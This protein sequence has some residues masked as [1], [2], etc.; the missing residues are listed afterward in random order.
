MRNSIFPKREPGSNS[1]LLSFSWEQREF[2]NSFSLLQN[3][4][5]SR[6]E[7]SESPG[8][9]ANIHYGDVL[10]KFGE[11]LDIEEET[12]PW[13]KKQTDADK[14]KMSFLQDGDIV[15]ADTAEDETAG[16]CCEIRNCGSTVIISG[17]HTIPCRP[18]S[19]FAPGYLGYYLNSTAF[20]EQLIP[21]MQGTK[22]VSISKTALKSTNIQYPSDDKEQQKIGQFFKS[23]DSL[24]TLHQCN[25]FFNATEM[26]SRNIGITFSWEQR[27]VG[28]LLIER[29][30]QAPAND[31]FPLMA[32]IANIG[33][34]PKGDRYD[35]S[36][37]V[38]DVENKLY[39]RTRLGDFIYSSNNL[40]TG[41]IGLNKYGNASISPVYSIFYATELAD[42]EFLGRR[43]VRK[44]FI[45]AMIKWRQGVIYGQWRIHES[46]FIKIKIAVPSVK[47]QRKIGKLL[48]E[49][50]RLITLHQ[51][52]CFFSR[53]RKKLKITSQK[54]NA[55]EQRKL[56]MLASFSKGA[57]YSKNDLL[58]SGTPIILYG[59]L[60]TKYE[61]NITIVNTFVAAKSGSIYSRGGE[62]IVPASG[63]T[64]EDISI[65]AVVENK[66][67]ILGGDLNIITPGK[68]LDPT[69]LAL[70]ISFGNAHKELSR[71]AQG[72]SVV[73]LHNADLK[74]VDISY[75]KCKEQQK[76]GAF[77]Q[78]LDRLI[79]LHQRERLF[80]I[81]EEILC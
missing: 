52:E 13:I 48:D 55:W 65:A 63:E 70:T 76:I 44:D 58:S 79:T 19:K 12:F 46:D 1:W 26:V 2:E 9:A 23:L 61:T 10:I 5:L 27:K 39:K 45:N 7:L 17:L 77:F 4:T 22:V 56:E 34:S 69:F 72:K 15:F 18:E 68:D 53:I 54:T 59:R 42:A 36:S 30:E 6:S 81:L 21:L 74:I 16:K 8:V 14:F 75:P 71:F 37:L 3:N 50:D 60:Y 78:T 32:F 67:V 66:G 57:G 33:V 38:S 31:D 47:E 35:R 29:N 51:R 40:E 49:L 73:H 20:H 64:A 24:V 43:F 28:E 11:Y 80:L 62:V 41:S 25:Y